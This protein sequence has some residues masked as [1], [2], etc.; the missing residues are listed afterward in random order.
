ML[1][2]P[3]VPH[4]LSNLKDIAALHSFIIQQHMDTSIDIFQQQITDSVSLSPVSYGNK[5]NIMNQED[6]KSFSYSENPS[7]SACE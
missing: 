6:N 3:Y 5:K 4:D 1:S 2:N 7:P